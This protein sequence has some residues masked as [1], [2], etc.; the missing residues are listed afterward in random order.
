MSPVQIKTWAMYASLENADHICTDLSAWMTELNLSRHIFSLELLARE[1][2]NNAIIHG[3]QMDPA[4]K[5]Y[6]ELLCD[7]NSLQLT[8]RDEG[9]GFNWRGTLQKDMVADNKENGRGLKLYQLYA[10]QVEF[11]EIGNQVILTRS[12]K[13]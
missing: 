2:L 6:A 5:I 12:L 7:E 10:D 1:A 11:N 13:D 3:S 9:S 8:V 4:K